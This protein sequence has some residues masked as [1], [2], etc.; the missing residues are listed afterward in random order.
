MPSIFTAWENAEKSSFLVQFTNYNSPYFIL[1]TLLDNISLCTGNMY[2]GMFLPQP[3][4]VYVQHFPKKSLEELWELH[5]ESIRYLTDY[6]NVH[7]IPFHPDLP[8]GNVSST[9]SPAESQSSEF[10]A[11]EI[12]ENSGNRSLCNYIRSLPFYPFRWGYWHFYRRFFWV[13]KTIQKQVEMGRLVLPQHLPPDYEKYYV[14]WSPE[15]KYQ[16]ICNK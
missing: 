1:E 6:G 3:P 15:E 13:N 5:D 11:F 14:M 7:L 9:D 10:S 8:W 16:S 4:G 12:V 2:D